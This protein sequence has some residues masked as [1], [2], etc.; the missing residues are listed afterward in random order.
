MTSLA[1]DLIRIKALIYDF[2]IFTISNRI[3]KDT[4]HWITENI[5]T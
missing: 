1:Y 2:R 4:L 3:S 5:T